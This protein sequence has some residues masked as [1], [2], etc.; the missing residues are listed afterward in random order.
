MVFPRSFAFVVSIAENHN[1]ETQHRSKIIA[2]ARPKVE[3]SGI[4]KIKYLMLSSLIRKPGCS[5]KGKRGVLSVVHVPWGRLLPRI[6]TLS[7]VGRV[8][9]DGTRWNSHGI[10]RGVLVR[11][12]DR[13]IAASHGDEGGKQVQASKAASRQAAKRYL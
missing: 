12:R 1:S 11:I 10:G 6:P 9:E 5:E 13:S 4:L 8:A 7:S 2:V 3:M